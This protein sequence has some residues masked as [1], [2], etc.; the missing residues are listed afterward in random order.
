MAGPPFDCSGFT[1]VR[2]GG[3]MS[4]EPAFAVG[5]T[6][7]E[8]MREMQPLYEWSVNATA[9]ASKMMRSISLLKVAWCRLLSKDVTWLCSF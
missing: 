5:I 9:L 6:I 1:Y 4:A 2:G 7:A 8:K 3:E